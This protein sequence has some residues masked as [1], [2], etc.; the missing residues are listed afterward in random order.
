MDSV[1]AVGN[2][3][4]IQFELQDLVLA[5]QEWGMPGGLPILALHG[6]LDNAASFDVLAPQLDDVHLV[7]LDCAGHGLSDHRATYNIWEDVG[8]LFEVAD[9]LGWQQFALLGHSR[10]AAICTLAA[11][12]FPERISH[13]ALLDGLLPTLTPA[14]EAPQQLARSIIDRRRH[15]QRGF[16]LYP[17]PDSAVL[18]RQRSEIPLSESAARLLV[19]RGLKEVDGGY[20]WRNDPQL[21][22]ASG[23]R[24]TEDHADAFVQRVTAPIHLTLAEEGIP[25]LSA[26]FEQL[27]ARY[28]QV[29]VDRLPGG[30]HLHMERES[31]ARLAPVLNRFFHHR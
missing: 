19:R 25:R 27:V 3:R 4:N 20:T 9:Q 2:S 30:H 18:V 1:T 14:E 23:F 10:G 16:A 6:W 28:P 7:A 31:A 17:D 24:L 13:L 22:A 29:Q 15:R 12:T 5:G 11:G 8:E 21:K 26:R